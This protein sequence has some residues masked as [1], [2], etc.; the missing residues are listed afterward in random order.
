MAGRLRFCNQTFFNFYNQTFKKLAA[1]D[2]ALREVWRRHPDLNRGSRFCR[3]VPYHLAMPPNT[4]ISMLSF[5]KHFKCSIN[6]VFCKLFTSKTT[7]SLHYTQQLLFE[8][9]F[10]YSSFSNDTI[11]KK[12]YP[13]KKYMLMLTI[14]SLSLCMEIKPMSKKMKENNFRQFLETHESDLEGE[15]FDQNIADAAKLYGLSPMQAK[16]VMLDYLLE[17]HTTSK[18]GIQPTDSRF[19]KLK[20]NTQKLFGKRMEEVVNQLFPR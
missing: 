15:E 17:S 20:A 19:P 7:T 18:F 5:I 12:G 9:F 3:P 2:V 4:N 1:P 11:Y 16:K 14:T 10:C 8:I 6:Y 13:M